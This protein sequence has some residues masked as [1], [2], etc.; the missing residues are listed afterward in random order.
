M[1]MM[2]ENENNQKLMQEQKELERMA[3]QRTLRELERR[4]IEETKRR[5]DDF[6]SKEK[7]IDSK[8]NE[9]V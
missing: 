1:A 5:K 3:D 8:A 6:S 2:Q 7:I 9:I 4:I